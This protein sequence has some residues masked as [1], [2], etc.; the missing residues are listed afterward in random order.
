MALSRHDPQLPFQGREGLLP[1]LTRF[2]EGFAGEA[3][4][5]DRSEAGADAAAVVRFLLLP[6]VLLLLVGEVLRQALGVFGLQAI[7]DRFQDL[8][9]DLPQKSLQLLLKLERGLRR[10]AL[11][12]KCHH[13]RGDFRAD[14]LQD[15]PKLFVDLLKFLGNQRC[16][17][18][19]EQIN[20]LHG[21]RPFLENRVVVVSFC[22]FSRKVAS[23]FNINF[24]PRGPKIPSGAQ[25]QKTL[26]P[27]RY[28]KFCY[29]TLCA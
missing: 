19:A 12:E 18:Q 13:R 2:L 3:A 14:F 4:Q 9:A 8:A 23:F 21:R 10:D 15:G 1:V 17:K 27:L 22:G 7:E 26:P 28:W 16:Q 5:G 11:R 29:N 24:R 6:A 25:T 20:I